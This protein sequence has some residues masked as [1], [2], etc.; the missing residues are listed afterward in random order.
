MWASVYAFGSHLALV[1]P[2]HYMARSSAFTHSLYIASTKRR[3]MRPAEAPPPLQPLHSLYSLYTALQLYILYTVYIP[4]QHPSA[5]P[6]SAV[7]SDPGV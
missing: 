5:V 3:Y 1:G 6:P 2:T 4:L 7:G